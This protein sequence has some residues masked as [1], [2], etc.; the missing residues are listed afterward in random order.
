L[1]SS[2]DRRHRRRRRRRSP[3]PERHTHRARW[4]SRWRLP[5]PW[6]LRAFPSF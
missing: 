1:V 3:S 4:T 2:T 6:S 5:C